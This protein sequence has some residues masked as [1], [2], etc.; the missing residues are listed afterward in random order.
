MPMRALAV[1]ALALVVCAPVFARSQSAHLRIS[2]ASPVTAQG[3]GFKSLEFVKITL[4]M[5][6]LKQV[7]GARA[8]TSGKFSVAWR[9]VSI[10]SCDWRIVAVGGLGSRASIHGNASVC[11]TLPPLD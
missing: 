8:T 10:Q 9:G 4:R 7:H 5:G 2:H 1:V 11:Q 6:H 3:S